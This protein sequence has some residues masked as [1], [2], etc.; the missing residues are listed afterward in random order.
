MNHYNVVD[1]D[2]ILFRLT[3][4]NLKFATLQ[5][6]HRNNHTSDEEAR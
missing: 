1:D 6:E 4:K 2:V 5:R 3:P